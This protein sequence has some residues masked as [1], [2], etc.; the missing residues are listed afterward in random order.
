[1]VEKFRLTAAKPVSTPMEP[2][3]QFSIDQC[4]SSLNQSARMH[5][6]PY[7]EA[8]GSMLWPVVV[9]RPDMAYA[10]GVLSQF[11]QNPGPAHW[12]GLKRIINYLGS[13]KDLWLTF[14][15]RKDTLIEGFCDADWASQKYRHSISGFSFHYGL[16]AV[17]WSL[18]KQNIVSLSSTEAEYVAQTHAAKEGI[19]LKSFISEIGGGEGKPLTISCDNQ[20]AI[21]L[22]KDNKFHARTKHIDLRYHFI[23]EAVENGKVKVK[24]VPTDDNVSDI[25]SKALPKPKFQW[26]VGLLGLSKEN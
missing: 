14:G 26:M 9:S 8:V 13:T 6:V 1:M 16:G 4:P 18:K 10:V 15:G 5:G 2:G 25:F 20:G 22:A 7:S 17:S 11:I 24:Y 3:A 12:E 23:H 19:W 21:A